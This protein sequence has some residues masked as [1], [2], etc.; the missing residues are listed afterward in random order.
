MGWTIKGGGGIRGG[1]TGAWM[2]KKGKMVI[3][4]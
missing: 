1:W 4:A 3:N 2:V